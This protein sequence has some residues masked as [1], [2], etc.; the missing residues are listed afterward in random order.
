[1][2]QH[3]RRFQKKSHRFYRNEAAFIF[4]DAILQ[5]GFLLK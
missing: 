3:E 2:E 1:M 5:S 4:I